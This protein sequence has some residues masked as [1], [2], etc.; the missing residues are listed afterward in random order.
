MGS[1]DD[2]SFSIHYHTKFFSEIWSHEGN[3]KGRDVSH[4]H[5]ARLVQE[6]HTDTPSWCLR[7]G[8]TVFLQLW[9]AS[10]G[11][12]WAAVE[13]R[14]LLCEWKSWRHEFEACWYDGGHSL[15]AQ[16]ILHSSS[17][18]CYRTNVATGSVFGN[19][20]EEIQI[21]QLYVEKC[22][23][24]CLSYRPF[25]TFLSEKQHLSSAAEPRDYSSWMTVIMW[26][27]SEQTHVFV[28]FTILLLSLLSLATYIE[29]II[30][31]VSPPDRD[32]ENFPLKTASLPAWES[33]RKLLIPHG[34][35]VIMYSTAICNFVTL[36]DVWWVR[37]SIIKLY[38]CI[39]MIINSRL[40]PV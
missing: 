38:N 20:Y 9:Y 15:T 22:T 27:D 32:P 36:Q 11:S 14:W 5:T 37:I 29:K 26:H 7:R 10:T 4:I 40:I 16:Q 24:S 1:K 12:I 35:Y 23:S 34:D 17:K 30:L 13:S 3:Q 6:S 25:V 21:Q 18:Q 39:H 28:A 2:L 8:G 31:T 33:D 19:L